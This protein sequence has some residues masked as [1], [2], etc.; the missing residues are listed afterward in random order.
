MDPV[1]FNLILSRAKGLSKE[2]MRLAPWGIPLVI[3]G[4]EKLA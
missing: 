1:A 4:E 2:L 3:G